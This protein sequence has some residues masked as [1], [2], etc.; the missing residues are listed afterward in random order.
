MRHVLLV[1][2]ATACAA[3]APDL[4]WNTGQAR[5]ESYA[6]V[7]EVGLIGG[8]PERSLTKSVD[9]ELDGMGNVTVRVDSSMGAPVS[10]TPGGHLGVDV[11]SVPPLELV[12]ML[13]LLPEDG[14]RNVRSGDQWEVQFP[15]DAEIARTPDKL[16]MQDRYRVT[17]SA[18]RRSSGARRV[19]LEVVGETRFIDN[20]WLQDSIAGVDPTQLPD[21]SP[22]LDWNPN[23]VGTATFDVDQHRLHA[24]DISMLLMPRIGLSHDDIRSSEHRRR[25]VF[26]LRP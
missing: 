24:A 20:Q 11:Q 1:L 22:F 9:L 8:V 2:L 18:V 16:S 6:A 23:L 5:T 15:S 7:H 21:L 14:A 26:S 3:C 25:V 4:D 12:I 13:H 19:D 10:I 17:V